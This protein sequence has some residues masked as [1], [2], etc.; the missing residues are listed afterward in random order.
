MGLAVSTLGACG[1]DLPTWDQPTV[2]DAGP[3]A[4][5]D[6]GLLPWQ[7]NDCRRVVGPLTSCVP[8]CLTADAC[9][10]C[11][12]EEPCPL[13][14][15]C[16]FGVLP[17]A[18]CLSLGFAGG[19]L[20]CA[21]DCQFALAQCDPCTADT[22]VAACKIADVNVDI[23]DEMAFDV[24]MSGTEDEL[25]V[26]WID[27][28]DGAQKSGLHFARF[29]N[30]LSKI[31]AHDLDGPCSARVAALI[32]T[33]PGY[34]LAVEVPDGSYVFSLDAQGG[35]LAPPRRIPFAL[36]PTLAG[37]S[38]GGALLTWGV[39]IDDHD[40]SRV[41][42][43]GAL[44]GDDGSEL[45]SPVTLFPSAG[46]VD[47][48]S[49]TEVAGGFLVAARVAD[50]VSVV[51]VNPDGAVADSATL[52]TAVNSSAA[53]APTVDGALLLYLD[54]TNA[55]PVPAVQHLDTQGSPIGPPIILDA[56]ADYRRGE[57]L[58]RGA[59]VYVLGGHLAP[60]S[61][62]ELGELEVTH[63]AGS[64]PVDAPYVVAKD[65]AITEFRFELVGNNVF[66]A[67]VARN[68]TGRLGLLR[69]DLGAPR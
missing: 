3:D 4:D 65:P 53:L 42:R 2:V 45:T 29:R 30:D 25:A 7:V 26:V 24:A 23:P 54:G 10:P 11:G 52:V 41:M 58:V 47:M 59:D 57:V 32:H 17:A 12:T 64:G 48:A 20:G 36:R 55:T 9:E 61:T 43:L 35:E 62:F 19:T 60:L 5:A 28:P 16:P 37:R 63:V 27:T 40:L 18:T 34:L 14:P 15:A 39:A 6:A 56:A 1:H 21:E 68:A 66:V 51:R 67:Y 8:R 49:S 69:L 13:D 33:A 44:I 38:D 50:G 31:E 22:H 46:Y